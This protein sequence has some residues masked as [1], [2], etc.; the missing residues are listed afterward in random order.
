MNVSELDTNEESDF[1]VS[2]NISEIN[3]TTNRTTE[4]IYMK[5]NL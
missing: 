1:I 2:L 5:S 4:R 3:G